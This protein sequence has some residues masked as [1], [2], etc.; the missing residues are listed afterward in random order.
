[1]M[2]AEPKVIPVPPD[3]ELARILDEAADG[4]VILVNAGKRFRVV[5]E[6]DDPF[7]GYDPEH[8]RKALDR[9]F[10]SLKGLDVDTFLKEV[11]EQRGQDR[12]DLPAER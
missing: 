12:F 1:M 11:R 10:G 5:P 7:A 8:V 6:R 2:V 3:S 9:S 4:D